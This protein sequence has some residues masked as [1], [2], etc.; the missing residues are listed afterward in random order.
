[1]LGAVALGQKSIT[2]ITTAGIEVILRL[3]ARLELRR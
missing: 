1:M 3:R 2:T